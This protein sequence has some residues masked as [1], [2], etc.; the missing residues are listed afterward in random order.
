MIIREKLKSDHEQNII[1]LENIKLT[2]KGEKVNIEKTEKF[3]SLLKT[4]NYCQ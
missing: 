1:H 4:L 3:V 2:V